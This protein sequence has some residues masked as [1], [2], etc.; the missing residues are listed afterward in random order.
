MRVAALYDIHGNLPALEAVLRRCARRRDDRR[1]RRRR[2]RARS[3]ARRSSALRSLG[4]RVAGSAATP[5]ASS[6][7]GEHGLAP[8]RCSTWLRERARRRSRSR[9]SHGLPPTRARRRRHVLFCHATPRND[10]GRSFTERD[11][12]GARRAAVRGRRR[13]TSSSAAT[14]T[15]SSTATSAAGAVVNAGSVGMPYEDEPG[16]YWALLGRR[17]ASAHGVRPE[18][19]E[20]AAL[21][22][23][24]RGRAENSRRAPSRRVFDVD[25]RGDAELVPVGR[26]GRPHGLDGSF[27]VERPSERRGALREGRDALRRRRAG[28]GRRLEARSRRPAGDPARPRASS[29]ARARRAARR[30]CRP[31]E[32]GRVLRLPAR[33]ARA[34]RRRAA[35][36]SAASATCTRVPCE[37]RA[38]ARL[39]PAPAARRGLR[40]AGRP[41]RRAN[42]C[43]RGLRRPG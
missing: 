1:R 34:S 15:C 31:P 30:R 41:R 18:R 37:R 14:R 12:R 21:G 25:R 42:R 2:R 32:R 3:R 39:G 43:R 10:I 9:S 35:G 29:A 20:L 26:V 11:A 27:F 6:T 23:P 36:C 5:T 4:D 7:P 8:P 40:A 22:I 24:G 13:A 38:R 28:E 33:R 16:A 19:R 17:R